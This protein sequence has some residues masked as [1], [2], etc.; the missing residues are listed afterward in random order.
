MVVATKLTRS[1]Q[2]LDKMTWPLAIRSRATTIRSSRDFKREQETV[3][4]IADPF[5][6]II[7]SPLVKFLEK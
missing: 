7:F 3:E 1:N 5:S 2:A 6:S 4:K